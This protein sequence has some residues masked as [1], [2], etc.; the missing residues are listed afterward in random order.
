M[1]AG[2][3]RHFKKVVAAENNVACMRAMSPGQLCFASLA[4]P[5]ILILSFHNL[6]QAALTVTIL[7]IAIITYSSSKQF[8]GK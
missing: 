7:E 4:S 6:T 2:I 1:V 3:Q 8:R 5:A